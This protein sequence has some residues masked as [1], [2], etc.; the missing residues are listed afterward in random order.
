MVPHRHT[1]Y[2]YHTLP[3]TLHDKDNNNYAQILPACLNEKWAGLVSVKL[4]ISLVHISDY[5][6]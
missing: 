6:C 4:H 5:S 3:P 1:I 2:D